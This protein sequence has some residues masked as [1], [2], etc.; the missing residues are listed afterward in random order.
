MQQPGNVVKLADYLASES[1]IQSRQE[2]VASVMKA[3]LRTST[4]HLPVAYAS[5]FV[6]P[7]GSVGT[8]TRLIESEQVPAV[9]EAMSALLARLLAFARDSAPKSI[10]QAGVLLSLCLIDASLIPALAAFH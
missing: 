9:A 8:D 10:F 7:D 2:A 3:A 1:N 6:M 5:V 4:E